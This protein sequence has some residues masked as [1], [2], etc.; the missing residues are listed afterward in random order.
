MAIRVLEETGLLPHL[1]PGVMSWEELNRLKPVS[2][3]MGMMLETTSRRLFEDQGRGPL[4]LSRQ[5]P[6][7]PAPGA[8]GRRP[9]L[10]PVHHRTA[11][12]DRRDAHRAGR[13]DPGAARHLPRVRRRA[14]GHRPEL[15]GQARHR[16]AAR[17]RPRPRR[18]PRHHRGHPSPARAQGARPGSAEPRRPRGVPGPA[19]RRHRR[20][21][22]RL[23]AHAR[24]REPRAAL[25]EPGPAR[26]DHRRVRLRADRRG[27]PCTR[28]T[29]SGASPGWTPASPRTSPP[30]PARTG[31]PGPAYGPSGCRGRSRTAASPPSGRTDLF[32]AVDT[33]GRTDDRRS[34]FSD[35]YGDWDSV[36]AAADGI[37][38]DDGLRTQSTDQRHGHPDGRVSARRR[39]EGPRQP[40]RRAR[41]DPDD[42]RGAAAASRS[43]RLADDLRRD[44][45][46]D[47]VTYVVNRN[48]NFTN[49]CYVGCRFCA[50][51]QRR[52]DADAYSLSLDEVAD[53]AA[54]GVGARG[55]R[56]LHAGRHRPGAAGHGVLRPGHR[57]Q[58]AGAGDARARV[59]PDGGRQ[60]HRAH[61][62]VDRGLPDQGPRGRPRLAARYGGRDPRRRGPLGAH[63]GQA[64]DPHLDRGR[65][66]RA[67]R[68]HPHDEHDDVRPRRQPAPLGQPPAGPQQD[69]G[70]DRRV[71]RV[72]AAAVR[73]HQRADLPG[74]RRPSRPD[75]ARQPRRPRDGPDPA[76]RPD[77][78]HPDELGQARRRR[79]PRDAA[80]RRQ[81]RGRHPDGGDHLPDGRLRA[82][83]GQD[84]RGARRD[85]CR[86]RPPV[87]ERTTTTARR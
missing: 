81:R 37:V 15:P 72:R 69:P 54:G 9:A 27:S 76:A 87:V 62:P 49:V 3:S 73:A 75:P 63:Q 68:R 26:G 51:A 39:R 23:A 35:V 43:C 50:F 85:R 36:Q 71:H 83:L 52:T 40:V 42:R 65:H 16:D 24:P 5:G 80:G 32:E 22:R 31:W 33:E 58:A 48:I 56:G 8:R 1:N 6:R 53:R 74:R 4:R 41:A 19:R 28:S 30:W 12:R 46:G 10:H 13:D 2:P 38:R 18:L 82:R 14:G 21:G 29:S 61:R 44:T 70:R 57:G 66:H 64:A 77:P 84:R 47:E 67:P 34:D 78:Q 55:D 11:G 60:R 17:R 7:R 59:Q 20:L 45:V 86:H 79:H 25:A